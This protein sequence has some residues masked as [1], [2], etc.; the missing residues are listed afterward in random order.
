MISYLFYAIFTMDMCFQKIKKLIFAFSG[1][2][3]AVFFGSCDAIDTILPSAGSYKLNIQINDTTL[4]ECSF[5]T[6]SDKIHPLFEESVSNDQDITGLMIFIK[7]SRGEISGSRVTYSLDKIEPSRQAEE[8][9][10]NDNIV[11]VKSLDEILPSY[12]MPDNLAAGSYSFVSQVVS[13][14]DI[15]QKTEK[16]FYYLGKTDFTYKGINVYLPGIAE[17]LQLIPKG[18]SVMLEIDM[19]FSGDFNPYIIWY[20]GR[21]KISEGKL[22]DGAEQLLWKAPEQSGFFSIRAEVFPV[23]NSDRLTGFSKDISLLISTKTVDMHLVSGDIPQ[24]INWYKFEG[25]LNDS[26]LHGQPQLNAGKWKSANGTYG[27]VTGYNNTVNLANVVIPDNGVRT[28]QTL[29]RFKPVNDGGVFSVSFES[30]R[31]VHMHLLMEEKNI[32]LS[33]STPQRTVSQVFSLPE[34]ENASVKSFF[35]VVGVSFSI[36]P[37]LLSAQINIVDDFINDQLMMPI[38]LDADIKNEFKIIL[39]ALNENDK[40]SDSHAGVRSESTVIWDEFAL[41]FRPP[42]DILT[43]EAISRIREEDQIAAVIP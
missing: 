15:L 39:G 38:T 25:N 37:G 4:D 40:F 29:F 42:M 28:W 9:A 5:I 31:N 36:T 41:Y 1:I 12:R 35:H 33:L 18:T 26:K 6:S 43:A 10:D 34:T 23:R 16:S 11:Y 24:L 2:F 7:D 30:S 22:S 8:Q 21:R 20:E 27:L 32:V 19:E 13:G 14:K 3:L 17:S